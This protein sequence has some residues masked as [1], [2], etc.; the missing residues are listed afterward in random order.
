MKNVE[1]ARDYAFRARRCLKEAELAISEGDFP[2]TVRRSQEALELATK[3]MLRNL[4][5]EYPREH[6]V[7]G[8]LPVVASRL[9]NYLRERVPELRRLLEE[10]AGARGPALYGYEREG[11]PPTKAFDEGYARG[12]FTEVKELVGLVLKFLSYE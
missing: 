5:V 8:A 1:M 7:G 11:V 4:A 9:P 2:G 6:D 10:L 12:V 3:A